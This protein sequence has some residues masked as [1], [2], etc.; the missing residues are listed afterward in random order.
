MCIQLKQGKY[1][2]IW[3]ITILKYCLP[4]ICTF[5]GQ[6]F[7]LLITVFDCRNDKTYFDDNVPCRTGT[8]YYYSCPLS[9]IAMLIQVILSYL[10]ISMNYY[11][12]FFLEENYLGKKRSSFPDIIF[13]FCKILIII[14]FVFDKQAENEHWGILF[15]LCFITG[16]NAYVTLFLQYYENLVMKQL[17][18]FYSLFLFWGFLSLL[19]S[20]IFR[21]WEFG[22]GIYLFLLGLVLI[23]IYCLF[24]AK[25]YLEFLNIN[26]SDF[27]NS[28]DYINYIK[29]YLNILNNKEI[30]RNN[31]M[32]LTTFIEKFEE[33]CVNKNCILKK[34]L[35][36]LSKGFDS[37]F[38]L[39]QYAQ[40]LYKIGLNKFPGDIT[41]KIHYIIFLLTKI[42]QKKNALKELISIKQNFLS[43]N[44]SFNLY[45]CKKYIEEYNIISILDQ[46]EGIENDSIF[47]ALEYKNKSKE[48]KRL[49]AKSSS[50]YYDFWSSLYS[51][52]LQGTEDVK[53][54]N[55]I[56]GELNH[57]IENI[58][59]IFGKLREIKNNDFEIIKL[60]ESYVKN[61]LNDKEKYEKYNKISMNILIDDKIENKE[62]DYT[63]FDL[64]IIKKD[65]EYKFIIISANNENRGTIID[66]SLNSCSIFGYH[67]NE[68]IGK[69]MNLLIPEIYHKIHYNL[70]NDI[71]EK[72]KTEFFEKLSKKIIYTPKFIEFSA[73]GRNKS[74]YLIPLDIK[75][76]FT[77]TEENDLVYIADFAKKKSMSIDF[78]EDNENNKNQFYCVLTDNNFIIQTFTANCAELLGLNSNKDIT[79]YIKQF[80]EELQS[81]VAS[82]AKDFSGFEASE[83][84]SND[85][86]FRDINNSN[87]TNDKTFENKIK[88]KRK[89]IKLKYSY[90]RKITWKNP[91]NSKKDDEQYDNGKVQVS[92]LFSPQK[93]SKYDGFNEITENKNKIQKN[94]LM[95]VKEAYISKKHIGYYFYFKK[96]N[97]VKKLSLNF[98]KI[99]TLKEENLSP[100]N[101]KRPSVK[102][103]P[104]IEEPSKSS[105][106]YK[107][108]DTNSLV[109][110]SSFSKLSNDVRKRNSN[111]NFDL[112]SHNVKSHESDK[113]LSSIFGIDDVDDKFIPNCNFNFFLDINTMSYN[114]STNLDS[115][116]K[117]NNLLRIETMNKLENLNKTKKNKDDTSLT[118]KTGNYSQE[119]NNSSDYNS[120]SYISSSKSNSSN[121][122]K[123][124]IINNEIEF[125]R[126]NNQRKRSII[127]NHLI[128]LKN[129]IHFQNNNINNNN[130]KKEDEFKNQYYKVN[131]NKIK[132]MI[133]DFNQEMAINYEQIEKKSQVDI[134]LDNYKSRQNINLSEDANY[135]NI[136]FEKYTKDSKNKNNQNKEKNNKNENLKKENIFDK[137]KEFEKEI[138]YA[139]SKQDEQKSIK[140][141]YKLSFIMFIIII[142]MS[143]VDIYFIIYHYKKLRDCLFLII[144]S[145]NLKYYTNYGIYFIRESILCSISNN[146]TDGNYIVPDED[147]ELYK[148][149]I[150]ESAKNIF[151]KCNQIL[152]DII[153]SDY[154]FCD[155]TLYILTEKPFYI[156]IFFNSKKRNITTTFQTSLIQI[157]S[158]LCNLLVNLD[159]LPIDHPNIY[160]FIHNSFNNLG[161][162]LN[163]QT[164]LFINELI[165]RNKYIR[166]YIV[167]II[168]IYLLI[169]ILLNYMIC[170]SYSSIILKKSSY[171]A[172]FYGIGLSLIKSSIKKCE[173]FIN[174]INQNDDINKAND[175][176]EEASSILFSSNNNFNNIFQDNDCEEK[177]KN[178]NYN[179]R[180]KIKK[181]KKIEEDKQSK[182]FR[183][184]YQIFLFISFLYL[185]GV[186]LIFL[187]LTKKFEVS[188]YFIEHMKIFHNNIIELFNGYREYLFDENHKILGLSVYQ[189]IIQK[190]KIYYLK[191]KENIDFL[192]TNLLKIKNLY[193]EDLKLMES[194]LCV[195]YIS[196][197]N[198]SEQCEEYM[199]GKEGI[200]S[201]GF[202]L[203][204]NLFIE[205]IRTARNYMNYLLD[206]N[207]IIG[208]L[209][210]EN[211]GDIIFTLNNSINLIFRMKVFNMEQ[212][213]YRLNII[214]LNII[215]QY[216]DKERDLT[217][218]GLDKYTMNEHQKYI[219]I[220]IAYITIFILIFSFYWIPRINSLNIEIYKTKNMLSILP[221]QILASLPNIRELLNISTSNN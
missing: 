18:Y 133:Y 198:S 70:F 43:I 144:L 2:I 177:N 98:N 221:I 147:Y 148:N 157:Y 190:E 136:Y 90:S 194:S 50:L 166:I 64:K 84:R 173:F 89:L 131:I 85:N 159:N 185:A 19:I 125:T 20:N 213:H 15:I 178:L 122:I 197:F 95:E 59:K 42:N 75:V 108:E 34:Y 167:L 130:I 5:F 7:L 77:Q 107:K 46:K 27:N 209:T 112:D 191:Y 58:E 56:G 205:E 12:D 37:N 6:T 126:R 186:Y 123:S 110:K 189:Y 179:K 202:F 78:F 135:A 25:T 102:F 124:S 115:I 206:E 100:K 137:E 129:G 149:N 66:M 175:F 94:L 162:G 201:L 83:L 21:S 152:E 9:I 76:F 36:S 164:E 168:C 80:N 163:T 119:D 169:H 154:E 160:N 86:S 140:T 161:E 69:S 183:K 91:K 72:T 143:I 109:P 22:G 62:I 111:V 47:R 216:I 200:I 150:T 106:I 35:I 212:T 134:I 29:S 48:F 142:G 79:D 8:W 54:L 65:D 146:I 4:L 38:L 210:R 182:K 1:S 141:F 116:K 51:S 81:M 31:S 120:S 153:G 44:D 104:I 113:V 138:I 180:N 39:L 117:L 199:G 195:S 215:L 211:N 204:V 40:K 121:N 63:N 97:P 158:S 32:V 45:R 52:H 28:Q 67:K 41:L 139:L 33:G 88:C 128:N 170:C 96:I 155:N 219:I 55:D 176:D 57:L 11:P 193:K 101:L 220:L 196:Y 99:D 14:I 208:N 103:L 165:L 93:K 181:R 118:S 61:I 218:V 114:P 60:Y 17:N 10:T 49:L 174:K 184:I 156:E 105:R 26:N 214:F 188:G 127:E 132:F 68:I 172:V 71:C 3:P 203:M 87:N 13:L 92:S 23:F 73:F 151:T 30:S 207:L 145:T 74:K 187:F 16:F 82:S 171:I 192:Y 217:F 53:R 24:Y